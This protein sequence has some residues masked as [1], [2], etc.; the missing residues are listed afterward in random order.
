MILSSDYFDKEEM[1]NT[2]KLDDQESPKT[3]P[4]TIEDDIPGVSKVD[5]AAAEP[6]IDDM[7]KYFTFQIGELSP[8]MFDSEEV[9][10]K[11][12]VYNKAVCEHFNMKDRYT[13]HVLAHLNEAGQNTVLMNI[14]SKLYDKI[15]ERCDDID[16]GEIPKTKGDITKL[17]NYS[18]M[19]ETIG[20]IHDLL[21]EYKQDSGPVDELAVA[22]SNVEARKDLFERAYKYNV[23][24]PIAMYTNVT[25]G[26]ITGVSYMIASC[27][28]FIKEPGANDFKMTVNKLSYAKSKDHLMYSSLKG[29]NKSCA[30]NDFDKAMEAIMKAY[31]RGPKNEAVSAGVIAGIVLAAPAIAGVLFNL[32]TFVLRELTFLFF[33]LKVSIHDSLEMFS[34]MVR[35]NAYELEKNNATTENDRKKV[36]RKQLDVADKLLRFSN[37]FVVEMKKAEVAADKDRRANDEDKVMLGKVPGIDMNSNSV[38]F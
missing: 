7:D 13:C 30:K 34:N 21:K 1:T 19:K 18:S 3:V 9:F 29:F 37:K 32:V 24:L 35:L 11:D 4:D 6:G 33:N 25:L 15:V 26:I 38:L 10:Y 20:I 31:I 2:V 17:P 28:E 16:Y 5:E 12:P 27:I 14:T 23:E 22:L 8:G 36:V